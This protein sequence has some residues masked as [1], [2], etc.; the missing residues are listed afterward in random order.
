MADNTQ[1]FEAFSGAF[2][3]VVRK[4][5][6]P[7]FPSLLLGEMTGPIRQRMSRN[8]NLVREGLNA[9]LTFKTQDSFGVSPLERFGTLASG[10]TI[11]GV[12][13][14]IAL[15]RFNAGTQWEL[16][17]IRRARNSQSLLK[18]LV[19]AKM[20][21]MP[22]AWAAFNKVLTLG[23]QSGAIGVYSETTAGTTSTVTLR[24]SGN[25]DSGL[26]YNSPKDA[27]RLFS[28][29]MF[30]QWYN[31]SDVAQGDPVFV[32]FLEY[33][34]DQVTFNALPTGITA[35]WYA[36]PTDSLG[37]TAGY[38]LF[39]PGLFDA[40]D[41]DNTFQG[42][43][44]STSANARFR[45]FV[46]AATSSPNGPINY[47]QMSEFFRLF[48]G[49]LGAQPPKEAYT[50]WEVIRRYFEVAFRG[51]VMWTNPNAKT[52]YVDGWGSTMIDRTRLIQDDDLPMDQVVIPDM[53]S[54]S[55][56]QA[57]EPAAVQ[58]PTLIPTRP[59]VTYAEL[60]YAVLTM[61]NPRTSGRMT[62]LSLTA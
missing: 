18:N 51:Q 31:G 26:V 42:I 27:N 50:P 34:S 58:P 48:S 36:V 29:S 61:Q 11:G 6:T 38:N 21:R 5:Y 12:E 53:S 13:T 28:D 52:E 17:D 43:D 62:G 46:H 40:I 47:E 49:R 45:S 23:P 30:V 35:G 22:A 59:I 44:R 7:L 16:E 24:H 20:D 15:L 37:L 19:S 14:E 56:Q 54:I 60:Y 3:D 41:D 25:T 4:A 9:V 32:T 33:L 1:L 2:E 39:G 57:G 8:S 55:V 10:G